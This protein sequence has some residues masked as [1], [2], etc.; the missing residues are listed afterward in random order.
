MRV[1]NLVMVRNVD[2]PIILGV[3]FI[4]P[5]L[6]RRLRSE[7]VIPIAWSSTPCGTC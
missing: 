3:Q 6:K 4:I 7:L 2:V 5:H 1:K